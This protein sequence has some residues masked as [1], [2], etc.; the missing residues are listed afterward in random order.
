M[1][2]RRWMTMLTA[3]NNK[4]DD[5]ATQMT[6]YDADNNDT[7]ADIDAAKKTTR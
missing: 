3:D 6:G 2:H 5:P 7:A 4:N 1:L